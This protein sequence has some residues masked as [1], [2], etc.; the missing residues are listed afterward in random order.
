MKAQTLTKEDA[1]ENFGENDNPNFVGGDAL[2]IN[3]DVTQ[4]ETPEQ[5]EQPQIGF[6]VSVIL[7]F[8]NHDE[9]VTIPIT[10]VPEMQEM[11][12]MIRTKEVEVKIRNHLKPLRFR[13]M[14][15]GI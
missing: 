12:M 10:R 7:T 11:T 15:R 5:P 4:E 3:I 13:I 6:D 2:A 9:N 8:Q 14:V 1:V